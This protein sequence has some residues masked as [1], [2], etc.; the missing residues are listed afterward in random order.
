[1]VSYFDRGVNSPEC[2]KLLINAFFGISEIDFV[3]DRH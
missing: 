2:M 1:M 3:R